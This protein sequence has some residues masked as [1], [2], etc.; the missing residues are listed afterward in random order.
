MAIKLFSAKTFVRQISLVCMVM[1]FVSCESDRNRLKDVIDPQSG[2]TREEFKDKL[3]PKH[4]LNKSSSS[5]PAIPEASDILTAPSAPDPLPD[6]LVSLSVTEDVPLK[7]VLQELSRLADVDMEIDPGI[8]GGI[9]LR[10][11]DR[12][13]KDVIERVVELGGLRYEVNKGIIKIERDSP[14]LVDYR[15]DFLNMARDNESTTSIDTKGLGDSENSAPSGSTSTINVSSKGDVWESVEKSIQNMLSFTPVSGATSGESSQT[16]STSS[17]ILQINKPAGVISVIGT[18]KQHKNIGAYLEN[19]KAQVSSQVLIEAKVVEVTLNDEYRSGID[20]TA[21]R[22]DA[23]GIGLTGKFNINAESTT[24]NI[25]TLSGNVDSGRNLDAA[26]SLTETFGVTKTISSPRINAINNQQAVLSFAENQVYFELE[27][28]EETSTDANGDPVTNAK[29]NSTLKTVPVGVI[30]SL[31]PSINMESKEITMHIRPTL[32]RINGTK[33]DPA[34]DIVL[35]RIAANATNQQDLT[36][37]KNSIPVIEVRQLDSILKIKSGEI[38][39]IGGLI[40]NE[41]SS[42]DRGVPFVNRTPIVGNLFKS[43]TQIEDVV[44]TVIFIKATIVPPSKNGVPKEDKNF[45]KNFMDRDS[46]PLAF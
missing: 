12:P 9:I 18:Y 32:S 38:M 13:F 31:Q 10:V 42:T 14:Y 26:V 11:K 36:G 44:E 16:S 33:D 29:V 2:M 3:I 22:T 6:K 23:L 19:V 4:D 8:T 41:S 15:V 25:F 30:L 34:V 27:V 5:E 46:R 24:N 45:Y 28:V 35:A 17:N 39:V 1:L 43:K 20:W 21:L 7:D 40:K 37:I